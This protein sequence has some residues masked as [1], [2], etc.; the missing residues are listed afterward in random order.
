MGT[1]GI[2]QKS[3]FNTFQIECISLTTTQISVENR[4]NAFAQKV[5]A[6][7]QAPNLLL[8]VA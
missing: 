7:F 5:I 4:I 3:R 8:N 1:L 6:A 2:R